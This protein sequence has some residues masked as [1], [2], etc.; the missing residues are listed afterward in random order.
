[1]SNAKQLNA[2]ADN[3]CN[4]ELIS[5]LGRGAHGIVY[6]SKRLSDKKIVVLKS[7][8]TANLKSRSKNDI[9]QE[10]NFLKSLKHPHIVKYLSCFFEDATFYIVMEYAEKGDLYNLTKTMKKNKRVFGEEEVWRLAG[11]LFSA[12]EFVHAHKIVHRD[13]KPLN[14]F[15]DRGSSI[16]VGDFGVSK[17]LDPQS[18]LR[19]TKVGT[20]LYL[21]P[22]VVQHLAYDWRADI[23]SAGCA[24][25]YIIMQR[26]PFYSENVISLGFLIV[27]KEHD[28]LP[29]V[30]SQ[31]LRE[32]VN[33]CMRKKPEGRPS[34]SDVLA[35][36][37]YKFGM[38]ITKQNEMKKSAMCAQAKEV[39]PLK[40]N[41]SHVSVRTLA[42]SAKV[43][44]PRASNVQLESPVLRPASAV[45]K[46]LRLPNDKSS[47]FKKKSRLN[48]KENIYIYNSAL[49]NEEMGYS[50]KKLEDVKAVVEPGPARHAEA[51]HANNVHEIVLHRQKPMLASGKSHFNINRDAKES[52]DVLKPIEA[53]KKRLIR[54][55]SVTANKLLQKMEERA[56]LRYTDSKLNDRLKKIGLPLPMGAKAAPEDR[57]GALKH[58]NFLNLNAN[59]EANAYKPKP[60]QVVPGPVKPSGE[61]QKAKPAENRE[62]AQKIESVGLSFFHDSFY[63]SKLS[64]GDAKASAKQ[65]PK[66]AMLP[67]QSLSTQP[68][69]RLLRPNTAVFR[70]IA[71]GDNFGSI[72]HYLESWKDPSIYRM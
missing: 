58:N 24:L 26:V 18:D 72:E 17:I 70:G 22:E 52:V 9:M 14:I 64:V 41:E 23:W 39:E 45:Q 61:Q 63:D 42:G 1:M 44:S 7:I 16:K 6:K 68:K 62:P 71:S 59:A 57:F 67:A 47:L 29:S 5:E 4:Y 43:N 20:P 13:I 31:E 51:T 65:R 69:A 54:P 46:E 55:S 12:L 48:L 11:Q 15:L 60:A 10:A 8:S 38:Q 40:K 36:Y 33:A 32:L 19:K 35:K 3:L 37:G 27:N 53:A 34:A 50:V 49:V 66:T 2:H 28:P 56:E 21:A 25:Y 30:Y